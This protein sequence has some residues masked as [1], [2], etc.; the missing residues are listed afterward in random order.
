MCIHAG[1]QPP[2]AILY[3]AETITAAYQSGRPVH[4]GHGLAA[5]SASSRL[6]PYSTV[7]GPSGYLTP[8]GTLSGVAATTTGT[9]QPLSHV[10]SAAQS[11]QFHYIANPSVHQHHGHSVA[12]MASPGSH[13]AFTSRQY[14]GQVPQMYL[15]QPGTLQLQPSVGYHNPSVV[16]TSAPA[17]T[18]QQS[19]LSSIHAV[20][21]TV[22]NLQQTLPSFS[23][24]DTFSS[25]QLTPHPQPQQVTQSP[26][27]R[28]QWN[29]PSGF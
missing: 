5:L 7:A 1:S 28:P 27:T 22:G 13:S 16:S 2:S 11:S 6:G 9:L 14:H 23:A 15:T 10:P 12:S 19:Q 29:A 3:P 26:L 24:P 25:S 4:T 17:Y 18:Q 20:T 21:G 8:S